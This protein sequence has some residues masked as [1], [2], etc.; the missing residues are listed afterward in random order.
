MRFRSKIRDSGCDLRRLVGGNVVNFGSN[1][2][3]N[4]IISA[5]LAL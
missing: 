2:A 5:G 4:S 3:L 1:N